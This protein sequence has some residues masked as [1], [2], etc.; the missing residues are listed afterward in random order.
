MRSSMILLYIVNILVKKLL[1]AHELIRDMDMYIDTIVYIYKNL[2]VTM[3]VLL[4]MYTCLVL[5]I[6]HLHVMH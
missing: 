1:W 2:L 5:V 3:V 4:G 6:L